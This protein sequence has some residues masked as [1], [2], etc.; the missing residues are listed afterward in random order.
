MNTTLLRH[1]DEPRALLGIGA[2]E[3]HVWVAR[4]TDPSDLRRLRDWHELLDEHEEARLDRLA[5]AALKAEFLLTRAL[6]RK[7]LSL[8]ADVAPQDWRFERNPHGKPSI[9]EP[10]LWPALRFNLSNARTV[11]ACAV[12]VEAEVGI[13]IEKWTGLDDNLP[14]TP[15]IF[16]ASEI[17]TLNER[18]PRA[19]SRLFHELWTLKEAYVKA[20]GKGLSMNLDQIAFD[21][22]AVLIRATSAPGSSGDLR[23]WQFEQIEVGADHLL[24]LAID[25]QSSARR[26]VTVREVAL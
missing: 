10:R 17:R 25:I 8:Y 5:T 3:V 11:V 24:A 16:S 23:G 15:Q 4:L 20:C 21:P 22:H 2:D 7:T 9:L 6:C 14:I 1:R 12:A 26:V 13:D 18:E 19:R